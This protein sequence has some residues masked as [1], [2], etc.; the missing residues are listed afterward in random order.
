MIEVGTAHLATDGRPL[1][2]RGTETRDRILR[3]IE[4]LV[5]ENGLR[6][7]RL[8]DI[9]QEVGFSTPAFYQY[10]D[11]IDGAVLALNEEIGPISE[12]LNEALATDWT[13][14]QALHTIEQFVGA[15]LEHWDR[16]RA[17]LR[18]RN[19]AAQD[20][21]ERWAAIR[22][23]DLLPVKNALARKVAA[24]QA[25]GHLAGSVAPTAVAAILVTLLDSVAMYGP[26]DTALGV[27]RRE[28]ARSVTLLLAAV[29]GNG[30]AAEGD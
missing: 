8:A 26:H 5:E 17:V 2:R 15:Y 9:A 28:L 19:I 18:A 11:D 13:G 3:S 7:L 16:H 30:A 21:N 10:F 24:A 23:Q 27:D 20:G 4:R 6:G 25:A 22:K 12:G 14:D 1:G 29:A